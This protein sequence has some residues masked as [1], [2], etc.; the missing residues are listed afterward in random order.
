MSFAFLFFFFVGDSFTANGCIYWLLH[1]EYVGI[2]RSCWMDRRTGMAKI[3]RML[4]AFLLFFLDF[5]SILL[6]IS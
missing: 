1:I 6:F 5:S 2:C 4:F 3:G